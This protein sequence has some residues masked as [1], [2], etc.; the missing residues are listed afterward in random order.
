MKLKSRNRLSGS[1]RAMRTK[2]RMH[3]H[4][5]VDFGYSGKFGGSKIT[6]IHIT[7]N[8]VKY[9]LEIIHKKREQDD[10]FAS[11]DDVTRIYN[12]EERFIMSRQKWLDYNQSLLGYGIDKIG[13]DIKDIIFDAFSL[14]AGFLNYHVVADIEVDEDDKKRWEWRVFDE[15]SNHIFT[16]TVNIKSEELSKG[17]DDCVAY[18]E[19][20]FD[21]MEA[22]VK[23][24]IERGLIKVYDR[25]VDS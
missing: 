4:V 8:R 21:E 2:F 19:S 24:D 12:V 14:K 18:I 5:G 22:M 17:M 10:K 7:E 13:E 23:G 11:S 16:Y 20:C 6:G 15:H 3:E 1:D 25:H 9:D